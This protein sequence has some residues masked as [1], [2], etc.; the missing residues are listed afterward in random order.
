MS[1]ATAE[2]S[3]ERRKI[4]VTGGS[5][6]TGLAIVLDLHQ[7]GAEVAVGTRSRD[8][9]FKVLQE[10]QKT[11]PLFDGERVHPFTA[12]I[13]SQK[14]VDAALI[15]LDTRGFA[16]TDVVHAAAGGMEPFLAKVG[17]G[18]AR[19]ARV[20]EDQH[21]AA[22]GKFAQESREWALSAMGLATS[23]NYEGP[24]YITERL[25]EGGGL[26]NIVDESSLWTT[27]RDRVWVPGFY[28]GISS[29]KG[30]FEKWLEVEDT[31]DA[32]K[33][34]RT[35]VTGYVIGDTDVGKAFLRFMLPLFP[36]SK[37]ED[38]SSTFIQRSDMVRAT[39]M[40]LLREG[41]EVAQLVRRLYVY[42]PNGQISNEL[43]PDSAVFAV[44]LPI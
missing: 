19:L 12:D 14:Q 36:E 40:A 15:N 26:N 34:S 28:H 1:T 18:M 11:D 44:R 8:N 31:L 29:T 42:G 5:R 10:L 30:M 7:A 4:L 6:G 37:Q 35:I 2:R 13:S 27:F 39:R 41:V 16:P 20:P 22:C 3:L 43:S 25:V 23:V 17:L 33:V 9:Y 32:A 21:E 38:V 24:R